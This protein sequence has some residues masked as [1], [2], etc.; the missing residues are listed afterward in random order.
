MINVLNSFNISKLKLVRTSVFTLSLIAAAASIVGCKNHKDSAYIF[1]VVQNVKI[2]E[3]ND[4]YIITMPD[5]EVFN[6]SREDIDST[7]DYE[8]DPYIYENWTLRELNDTNT[9]ID[10]INKI[11]TEQQMKKKAKDNDT[12][13]IKRIH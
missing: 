8:Y 7:Y 3:D 10:S 2:D 11:T 4:I 9:E 5:G 13:L 1:D 6:I 12:V